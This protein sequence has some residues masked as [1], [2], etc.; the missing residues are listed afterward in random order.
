MVFSTL[1]LYHRAGGLSRLFEKFFWDF[2]A[3]LTLWLFLLSVTTLYQNFL[4]M[5]IDFLYWFYWIIMNGLARKHLFSCKNQADIA[6]ER[7][8][9]CK[10]RLTIAS[11]IN[12]LFTF[13]D[14]IRLLR[15]YNLFIKKYW[16]VHICVDLD[17]GVG[18]RSTQSQ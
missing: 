15:I 12:N 11:T 13:R 18:E 6:R 10:I 17:R 4:K 7:M 8:F 14:Q 2:L 3:C 5:S 9:S 16:F 1:L